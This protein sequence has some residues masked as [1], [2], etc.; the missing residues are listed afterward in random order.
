V[1]GGLYTGNA[2]GLYFEQGAGVC[3]ALGVSLADNGN[4]NG[5]ATPSLVAEIVMSSGTHT[6]IKGCDLQDGNRAGIKP[7]GVA[8]AIITGNV[9]ENMAQ[10]GIFMATSVTNK[11][12]IITH[13]K[14]S[15]C[16]VAGLRIQGAIDGFIA[17]QN[18]ISDCGTGIYLKPSSGVIRNGDLRGNTLEGNTTAVVTRSDD[19]GAAEHVLL[20]GTQFYGNGATWDGIPIGGSPSDSFPLRGTWEVGD[21]TW[22][23][24]PTAGGTPGWTC[25][26][27]QDTEMRVQ[28]NAT[29]TIMEVDATA[30]ILADDVIGIMLDNGVIHWSTVA[31]IT[32]ADTLVID[33][34]IPVDR[35]APVDADVYSNRWMAL[36]SSVVEGYHTA[37]VTC[38]TS[39]GYTLDAAHDKLAYTK[40]GRLVHI[41]GTLNVTGEDAPNGQLYMSLPFT[42][43]TL[44]ESADIVYVPFVLRDHGDAGIENPVFGWVAGQAYVWL[45]NMSDDGVLES[46]DETR[47]DT[48]F[49]IYV[50]FSYIAA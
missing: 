37:T 12:I 31:S 16:V 21:R 43:A 29:D 7:N 42:T 24:A 35:N 11:Q 17:T 13:N 48:A 41:Q 1:I 5:Y 44:D 22:E 36:A 40:M 47:V 15:S 3:S 34:A 38:A 39:G 2:V 45:S 10:Q 19:F 50:D 6:I 33:D 27:K 9:I 8:G 4:Q 49:R 28:A 18:H 26:N 46:I 20:D 30:G 32:D 25:I 14:I 23:I